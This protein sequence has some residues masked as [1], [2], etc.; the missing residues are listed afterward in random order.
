MENELK[1]FQKTAFTIGATGVGLG[2]MAGLSEDNNA[3][4][5]IGN[6]GKGLGTMGNLAVMDTTISMLSK[7]MKK[8]F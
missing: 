2:V 3:S 8:R 5:A 6:L 4:K 7:S 1:K